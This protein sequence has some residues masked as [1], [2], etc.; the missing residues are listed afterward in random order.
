M[1]LTVHSQILKIKLPSCSELLHACMHIAVLPT[2]KCLFML[3]RSWP[4][5][6]RV[7]LVLMPASHNNDEAM[8][9]W[10]LLYITSHAACSGHIIIMVINYNAGIR[11]AFDL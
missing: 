7:H 10:F 11:S 5:N 4:P 6:N 1:T 2:V 3:Y 8:H 9:N